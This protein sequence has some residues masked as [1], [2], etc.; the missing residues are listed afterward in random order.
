MDNRIPEEFLFPPKVTLT[1]YD[2][3]DRVQFS[4]KARDIDLAYSLMMY[5]PYDSRRI[6]LGIRTDSKSWD[7]WNEDRLHQMEN[8]IRYDLNFEG[9]YVQLKRLNAPEDDC[10]NEFRWRLQIRTMGL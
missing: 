8:L 7:N 9:Y 1:F 10:A 3:W 4:S 5:H 6:Y 2:G